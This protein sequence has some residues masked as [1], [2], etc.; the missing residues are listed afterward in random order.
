[1][2]IE[3]NNQRGFRNRNKYEKS[4]SRKIP[5]PPDFV[6]NKYLPIFDI[7][8]YKSM[9]PP[10]ACPAFFLETTRSKKGMRNI[11]YTDFILF[12]NFNF[13]FFLHILHRFRQRNMA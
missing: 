9:R 10:N 3:K 12:I 8:K 4:L 13:L 1:M 6:G 11:V 7:L 2:F 5:I